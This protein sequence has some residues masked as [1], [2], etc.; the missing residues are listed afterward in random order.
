MELFGFQQQLR[1]IFQ[2]MDEG[3]DRASQ[4]KLLNEMVQKNLTAKMQ[5]VAEA[6]SAVMSYSKEVS[7]VQ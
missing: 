1:G 5:D 7:K 2:S 4:L 6:Q 3:N